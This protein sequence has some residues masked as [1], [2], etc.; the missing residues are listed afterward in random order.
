MHVS[1]LVGTEKKRPAVL[2]RRLPVVVAGIAG[3]TTARVHAAF[4]HRRRG[5]QALA[6]T[7]VHGPQVR[8]AMPV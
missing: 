4:R 2:G 6:A 8:V 7:P 3:R 5:L 1:I